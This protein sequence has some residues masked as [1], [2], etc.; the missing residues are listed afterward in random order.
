MN[1]PT[2][3]VSETN[4]RVMKIEGKNH[5]F[6]PIILTWVFFHKICNLYPN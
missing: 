6:T 5:V 3:Q 1:E 2:L 4:K